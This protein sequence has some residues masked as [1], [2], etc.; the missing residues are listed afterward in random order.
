MAGVRNIKDFLSEFDLDDLVNRKVLVQAGGEYQL[1]AQ[2][3][4]PLIA[5][6]EEHGKKKLE[7]PPRKWFLTQDRQFAN[8]CSTEHKNGHVTQLSKPGDL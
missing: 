2:S 3:I 5:L 8:P 7:Y 6:M 1:R 4:E